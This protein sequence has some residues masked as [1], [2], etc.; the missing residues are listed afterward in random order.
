MKQDQKMAG[1]R[2][3]ECG[4]GCNIPE[5]LDGIPNPAERETK[6]EKREGEEESCCSRHIRGLCVCSTKCTDN[7]SGSFVRV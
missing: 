5:E 2:A 4:G 3:E 7:A 6:K 1:A